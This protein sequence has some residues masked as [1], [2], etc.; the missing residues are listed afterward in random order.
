MSALTATVV[1]QILGDE[2]SVAVIDAVAF[3]Q[4]RADAPGHA[5]DH[6]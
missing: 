3:Q 4:R 6:L 5:A 1:R 2:R